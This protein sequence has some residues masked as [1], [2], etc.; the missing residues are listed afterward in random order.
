MAKRPLPHGPVLGFYGDD[1][2]GSTDAMEILALAGLDPILVTD[3]AHADQIKGLSECR[4]VGIAGISRSKPPAWMREHLPAAFGLLKNL[5][6]P[7]C[8]YKVCSTFDS[9]PHIGSIGCALDIGR[10]VFDQAVVPIVVGVPDL[11][12]Y[13][14]F[15]TLFAR[16][17]DVVHRLDRHPNMV[18]HPVTPMT[19]ADLRDHLAAQTSSPIA[20]MNLVEMQAD[21]ATDIFRERLRGEAGALFLDVIDE[22]TSTA[23]GRL[24]WNE[25]PAPSFLVGSSGIEYALT[26]YWQSAGLLGPAPQF[27]PAAEVGQIIVVSG[28]CSPATAAQI[29]WAQ[30]NHFAALRIDSRRLLDGPDAAAAYLEGLARE[31]RQAL[32][33][34]RSILV[35]SATGSDDP[36]IAAF[37][38]SLRSR[39]LSLEDGNE[40]IGTALAALLRLVLPHTD[41]RRVVVAGGDTSGRVV[42]DL[43][44]TS[45]R[46]KAPLVRG[47]P[48]CVTTGPEPWLE[49]LELVL[50]GGQVGRPDFLEMVRLGRDAGALRAAG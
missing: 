49:G 6:F 20:L 38:D 31:A 32:A 40:K 25:I 17:G 46:L 21:H 8:H 9:A 10:E 39:N 41:C 14:A 44:I 15:G 35:F 42:S 28:S 45:L 12:R 18:R 22:A 37:A 1:F 2:T 33:R 27:A 24:L 30:Q 16:A 26:R 3:I 48:L 4:A 13:Q 11:G 43:G 7:L 23:A 19:E 36:A 34:G 47:A 50:K 29:A 5:G